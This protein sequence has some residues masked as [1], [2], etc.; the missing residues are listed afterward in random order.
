MSPQNKVLLKILFRLK[1]HF[2]DY[3]NWSWLKRFKNKQ[4]NKQT[5]KTRLLR[6]K[7]ESIVLLKVYHGIMHRLTCYF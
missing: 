5:L 2:Q 6:T 1:I 7:K 3:K 4:T